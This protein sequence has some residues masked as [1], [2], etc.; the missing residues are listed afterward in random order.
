[1]DNTYDQYIE[2]LT[3]LQYKY[4]DKPKCFEYALI[5]LI[6][7]PPIVGNQEKLKEIYLNTLPISLTKQEI[8]SVVSECLKKIDK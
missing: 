5:S 7:T 4:K 2:E 1:M 8:L 3:K 6:I